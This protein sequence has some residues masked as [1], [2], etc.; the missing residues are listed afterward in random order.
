MTRVNRRGGWRST[1]AAVAALVI[2]TLPLWLSAYSLRLMDLSLIAAVAVIGMYF[3]FGLTGFINLCQAAFCGIGAY[4]SSGLALRFGLPP[5]IATIGGMIMAALV[6]AILAIPMLRLRGHYLALTTV[7]FNVTF[8]VVSRNWDSLTGG[9]DGLSGIPQLRF[10]GSSLGDD[11]QYFYICVLV[12]GASASVAGLIRL[13]RFGRAMVSVGDNALAAAASGVDVARTNI[14]AFVLCSVYGAL[15]GSLYAHFG[16][17][18]SPGDFDLVRSIM[19]LSMLIVGGDYSIAGAIIGA[20]LLTFLPE[21]LR[22]LGLGYLAV[23]SVSM[24]L[25]LV[26]MPRGIAGRITELRRTR[27]T[28]TM[29]SA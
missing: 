7:G 10:A 21:W 22:F 13:S 27:A 2:L 19:L 17:Y 3:A 28:R 8:E 20:I 6:A 1:A 29:H 18:I 11:V 26:G 14:L 25:I 9:Y 4:T 12:L 23:F 15:S 16:G 24:L 5:G